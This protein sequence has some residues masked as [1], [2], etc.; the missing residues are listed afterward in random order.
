MGEYMQVYSI[1]IV[2]P[3]IFAFKESS[4]IPILNPVFLLT[5]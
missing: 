2:Y 4:L 5:P 3:N 1:I